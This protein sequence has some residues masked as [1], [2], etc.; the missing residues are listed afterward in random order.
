MY[1][2]IIAHILLWYGSMTPNI[3]V[4]CLDQVSLH[5][6]RIPV[7]YSY[8]VLVC[9]CTATNVVSVQYNGGFLPDI[10]L[11]TPCYYNTIIGQLVQMP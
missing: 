6:Y 7:Q 8:F 5:C 9:P 2:D 4:Y 10:I 3:I 11:L 1:Y